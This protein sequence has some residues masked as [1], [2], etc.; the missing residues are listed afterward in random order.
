M[1]IG[2]FL[3]TYSKAI[4]I[5]LV[6][7][8]VFGGVAGVL[9]RFAFPQEYSS[10]IQILVIQRYTLTD[11]YTASKS[12][13]KISLNLAE[14][15]KTSSF[16]DSVIASNR[17]DLGDLL[18]LDEAKQRDTWAHTLDT[19]VIANASILKI[20]A[21]DENPGKAE[22]I[23]EAVAA[24]LLDKGSEYHGA[25][26]TISLKVVDTA[27]TSTYPTRPNVLVNGAAA[28]L[29]GAALAVV[30]LFL[31]TSRSKRTEMPPMHRPIAGEPVHA[32]HTQQSAPH[33]ASPYAVLNVSNFHN[34][35]P[36]Q[37]NNR[38]QYIPAEVKTLPATHQQNQ[39]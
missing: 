12:A 32:H 29:F 19:E 9:F 38:A 23:T 18:L 21:Y 35:L 34:H 11:S 26:D 28:A 27:L 6:T 7:A 24:V 1:S 8:V 5:V 20:I 36:A 3:K 13:E 25:P 15:V 22:Q 33:N 37:Q 30:M 16:L 4:G 31:R 39:Q 17:V 14:V 10:E 2:H